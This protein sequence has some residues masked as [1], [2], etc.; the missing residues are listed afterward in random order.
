MVQGVKSDASTQ[1]ESVLHCKSSSRTDARL[2][3]IQELLADLPAADQLHIIAT[4][5]SSYGCEHHNISIPVDFLQL[6]LN[7][8]RHLQQCGRSNIIY[9][10]AKGTGSMRDDGSD[11]RLPAKRMPMGMLEYTIN[12]F[13]AAH[14]TKVNPILAV[15]YH[16]CA[17]VYS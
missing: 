12:F 6:T 3:S 15:L 13:I 16:Y 9:G 11:S 14:M 4:L 10:L 8:S 7:G 2:K 1:T 5:F 17:C